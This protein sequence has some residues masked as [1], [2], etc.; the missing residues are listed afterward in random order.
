MSWQGGTKTCTYDQ[1]VE[2]AKT[3]CNK[4]ASNGTWDDI[5]HK[6]AQIMALRKKDDELTKTKQVALVTTADKGL[7]KKMPILL[8]RLV[9]D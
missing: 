2:V 7:L 6:H 5:D 3:V 4:M 8:F 1:L 9:K